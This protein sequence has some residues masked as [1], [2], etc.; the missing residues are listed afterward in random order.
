MTQAPARYHPL[1][2]T[3][4]WLL[5]LMLVVALVMGAVV[6]D[7]TPNSDPEKINA[8]RGHMI[9]GGVILILTLVR[10][11]VRFTT[12]APVHATTGNVLLDKLGALVHVLLNLLVI[13]MAGSGIALAAS[14]GLPDIVFG[15]SG[16]ALPE[17]F[18]AFP[19]RAAHG[20]IAKLL[21]ATIVLHIVG[22]IYHQV[23]LKDGLMKRVWFGKR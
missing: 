14:A 15:G 1:L 17:S 9:A 20:I 19:A 4:H 6:L 12:T 13:V 18:G 2:V 8:L 11:F 16:Q 23:I 3:L 21:M 22:A 7:K 10:I 5:A